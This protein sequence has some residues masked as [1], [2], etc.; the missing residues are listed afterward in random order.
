MCVRAWI[1]RTTARFRKAIVTTG[2]ITRINSTRTT[3]LSFPLRE[4]CIHHEIDIPVTSSS[5]GL[6]QNHESALQSR[7]AEYP[8]HLERFVKRRSES[9]LVLEIVARRRNK[10]LQRSRRRVA[11]K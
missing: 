5:G 2:R 6:Q 8:D 1:P 3:F 10:R 7:R 4:N 9:Y 11:A